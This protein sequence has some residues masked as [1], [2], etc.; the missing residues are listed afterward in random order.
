MNVSDYNT[1]LAFVRYG[2]GHANVIDTI[3]ISNWSEMKELAERQELSAIVLDGIDILKQSCHNDQCCSFPPQ[4]LALQWIGEVLTGYELRYQQYEKALE[5]LS[6]F[7]NI[8]GYRMMVLKGYALSLDWPN[9]KH[10]PCG[11]ID[12][13]Q[14]GEY[15]KADAILTKEKGIKIDKTHHHHT[16]FYW[17]DFMVE[18]HYDFIEVQSLKSNEELEMLFKEKGMDDSHYVELNDVKVYLPSPNLHALF[19]MRHMVA[20]FSSVSIT[21]RQ[22]LD[23]AFLVEKHAKEIDWEWLMDVL[24]KYHMKDFFN[25]INAICVEDLGFSVD[26]F[27]EVQFNHELKGRVLEDIL[28]PEYVTNEPNGIL[29]RVI[30]KYKRWQ[31]N[32]WKQKLCF[33]ENRAALFISG[34][35]A[36]LLKPSWK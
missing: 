1:F 2:I 36:H 10:R 31:G 24:K 34:I 21:L 12:I 13:W 29:S 30:Y 28:N 23:W 16:I 7:Y 4:Q 35:C 3:K 20:H 22:V 9:P 14:F 19:L 26:I 18:N 15:K 27:P 17:K 8:H 32:S 25:I 5:T 33:K 11:D 6:G